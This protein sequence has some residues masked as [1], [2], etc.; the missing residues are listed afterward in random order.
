MEEETKN[1]EVLED[2]D[3]GNEK[4][5]DERHHLHLP[6][7]KNEDTD[8]KINHHPDLHDQTTIHHPLEENHQEE[9]LVHSILVT[10]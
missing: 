7:E 10:R 1:D 6:E 5:N 8:E 3:D 9:I 4:E 2:H